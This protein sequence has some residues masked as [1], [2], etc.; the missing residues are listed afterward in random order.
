MARQ[1]NGQ[2]WEEECATP[3][4]PADQARQGLYPDGSRR[5]EEIDR[6]SIGRAGVS[7]LISSVA[8]LDFFRFTS[9]S[10]RLGRAAWRDQQ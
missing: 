7:N 8:D 9:S 6:L 10:R 5:F 4:A 3:G 2:A 1:A